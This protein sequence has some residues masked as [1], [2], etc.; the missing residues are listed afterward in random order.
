MALLDRAQATYPQVFGAIGNFIAKSGLTDVC[1]MEFEQGIIVTGT[2]FYETG[3]NY[4][5]SIVTH[6]L[7]FDDLNRLIKG[8]T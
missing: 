5:R 2:Q 4:N 7:S 8:V 1:V 6:V 3:E